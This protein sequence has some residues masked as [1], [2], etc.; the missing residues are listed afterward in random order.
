MVEAAFEGY[1]ESDFA[2]HVRLARLLPAL[3]RLELD[4]WP[5]CQSHQYQF[6]YS[7]LFPEEVFGGV[8]LPSLAG[9]TGLSTLCA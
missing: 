2:E 1:K 6:R 7:K 3:V 9:L 8:K 4:P 5:A